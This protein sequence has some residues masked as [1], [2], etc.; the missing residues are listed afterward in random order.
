MPHNLDHQAN[1]PNILK[2]LRGIEPLRELYTSERME[3]MFI[4]LRLGM[5]QHEKVLGTGKRNKNVV[6]HSF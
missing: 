4:L 1:I 3:K 6:L 2:N 5:L